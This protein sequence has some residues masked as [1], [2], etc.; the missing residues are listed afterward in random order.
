[1]PH[2]GKD[3]AS[4]NY[5]IFYVTWKINLQIQDNPSLAEMHA[6]R[7]LRVP[8]LEPAC[9]ILTRLAEINNK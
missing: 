1:M 3:P 5:F 2:P 8:L 4:N 7:C 6:W 9:S